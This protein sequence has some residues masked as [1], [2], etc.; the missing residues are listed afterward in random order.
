MGW[1]TGIRFPSE[2][3]IFLF[4]TSSQTGTRATLTSYSMGRVIWGSLCENTKWHETDYSPPCSDGVRNSWSYTSTPLPLRSDVLNLSTRITLPCTSDRGGVLKKTCTTNI[5]VICVFLY[6][7]YSVLAIF[8]FPLLS[9]VY[10]F[11]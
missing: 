1:V 5:I 10:I 3:W 11:F 7:L 6:L 2:A 9:P 8:I 4:S